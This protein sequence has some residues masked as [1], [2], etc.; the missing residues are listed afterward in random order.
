M[1]TRAVQCV[2]VCVCVCVCVCVHMCVCFLSPDNWPCNLF[3]I[4]SEEYP[5]CMSAVT[6]LPGNRYGLLLSFI[7]EA[8][9]TLGVATVAA[10]LV[11][12][13]KQGHKR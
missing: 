1:F 10:S 4:V 13:G 5:C 9:C 3:D 7:L 11:I 6:W 2:R 8:K 12:W